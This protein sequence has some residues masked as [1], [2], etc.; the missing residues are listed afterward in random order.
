MN[1]WEIFYKNIVKNCFVKS[2]DRV[3][4]AVSGGADSVCMAHLFWRLKKKINIECIIINFNHNLRKESKKEA[5]LVKKLAGVFKMDCLLENIDVQEYSKRNKLSFETAGR[6][7][8]YSFLEKAAK[9][10]KCNK[11][12]TAHNANDNAET[13]IMRLLRG[14]GNLS[15]I[16]A[17]RKISKNISIIRPLLCV[18]R[19]LI[20][21]YVKKHALSFCNDKSNF[22]DIYTRN[23]IRLSVMPVFEKINPFF[24]EHICSLSEIQTRENLYLERVAKVYLKKI[25]KF[26]KNKIIID[27]GKFLKSDLAISYRILKEVIPEKKYSGHINLIMSKILSKETSPYRLSSEWFFKVKEN[28][29]VFVKNETSKN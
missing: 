19:K 23:K 15:G 21:E 27:L 1:A 13:V 17:E 3:V 5:E 26:Y 24:I 20:D 28:L 10:Y 29:G 7:I 4:L 11:I 22:M 12:A 25:V 2:G 9:K 6:E 16:P 8:R 14:S 18:K